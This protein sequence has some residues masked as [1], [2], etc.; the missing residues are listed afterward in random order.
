MDEGEM[1]EYE[2]M[3]CPHVDRELAY[4][5]FAWLWIQ[6]LSCVLGVLLTVFIHDP[7]VRWLNQRYLR[8]AQ[9]TGEVGKLLGTSIARKRQSE[10][11]TK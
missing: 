2:A 8:R 5:P 10:R 9:G 6:L 3:G 7:V 1:K 4:I 11:S